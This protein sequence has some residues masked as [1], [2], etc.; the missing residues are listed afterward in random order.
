MKY[1]KE[2]CSHN[3][4]EGTFHL[5]V[6]TTEKRK[7]P[8]QHITPHTT[9][10]PLFWTIKNS[11]FMGQSQL[12]VHGWSG[13]N[14]HKHWLVQFHQIMLTDTL[15]PSLLWAL[16]QHQGWLQMNGKSS[17]RQSPPLPPAAVKDGT[18]ICTAHSPPAT[19]HLADPTLWLKHL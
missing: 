5:C 3:S 6:V 10:S 15:L 7:K 12:I 1:Q 19:Q 8:K 9:S 4:S 11:M 16:F 2:N 13:L 17:P 18:W 14:H